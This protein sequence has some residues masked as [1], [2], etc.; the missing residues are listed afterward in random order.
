MRKHGRLAG[1][2]VAAVLASLSAVP[3]PAG[4]Q[5]AVPTE[6]TVRVVA[7]DAKIVGSGVGGAR[8]EVRDADTGELLARGVQEGGT[9]DTR[10]IMTEPHPRDGTVFDTRGAAAYTA[11]LALREPTVVEIVA[12][13]PL[14]P[15]HAAMR[16]SKTM[17]VIPGMDVGGEGIVLVLHGFRVEILDPGGAVRTAPGRS[18]PVRAR[19]TMMCG[20]PTEPGGLWDASDYTLEARLVDGGRAV[21]SAPLS[22]SG[23]TSVFRGEVP[24]RGAGELVLQVV[25]ADPEE[26]N[27]GMATRPVTVIP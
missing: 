20:C 23:V 14:E 12:E 1:A 17:L 3:T 27:F 13:G 11:T 25:A 16:A 15:P 5:E 6:L 19:V 2:A 24:V 7:R 9:G 4:A 26:A 22:F 8:V 10:K 21:A 18:L